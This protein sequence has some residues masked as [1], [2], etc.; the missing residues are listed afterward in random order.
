MACRVASHWVHL[1]AALL[2]GFAAPGL[3][4]AP[5][6]LPASVAVALDRAGVPRDALVAVVQ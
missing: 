1:L 5:E 3:R 4:A 2:L 6:S